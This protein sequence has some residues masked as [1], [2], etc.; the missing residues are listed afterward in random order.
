MSVS[1][2]LFGTT[3]QYRSQQMHDSYPVHLTDFIQ[4]FGLLMV[5]DWPTLTIERVS[6]NSQIY[7]GVCAS[8]M[9]GGS[10]ENFVSLSEIERVHKA[11]S[12]LE[13]QPSVRSAY[14]RLCIELSEEEDNWQ[15]FDCS[16]HFI[17]NGS[18]SDAEEKGIK[19]RSEDETIR[20]QVI[21]EME[22][23]DLHSDLHSSDFHSM[24]M[25]LQLQTQ[26]AHSIAHLRAIRDIHSFTQSAAEAM[27]RLTGYDRVMF[28]QFDEQSAGSVIAEA[29]LPEDVSYLG[30]RYPATDIPALVRQFYQRGMVRFVPDLRADAIALIPHSA[31]HGFETTELEV[32]GNSPLLDNADADTLPTDLTQAVL[33][34]VDPCCVDFHLNMGVAGFLVLAL[35]KDDSLW[36]LIACHHKTPKYLPYSVRVTAE[37]LSQFV[38][39][40]LSSKVNESDADYLL[41]IK[42]I[43]SDVIAAVAHSED[44]KQVLVSPESRLLELVNA[45]GVAVCLDQD[46]TLIGDTPSRSQVDTLIEWVLAEESPDLM[47][48]NCLSARYPAAT[49]YKEVASGALI[50]K[51]SAIR[52]YL[53]LW[54]R[55][56][57]V[58]TVNWAG[59]PEESMQVDEQGQ[60]VLC[61]RN[62]FAQWKETVQA[63]AYPWKKAEVESAYALK[64]AIV[65]SVL[66][67][68]DE[69]AKMNRAL[70]R[71]NQ[72]LDSFA[73]AASH[74]LKEPLRGITNFSNILLRRHRASLDETGVK[75]LETLVRL[76]KRMDTLID[77]LLRFSRLG[78]TEL[79]REWVDL[80]EVVQKA[81]DDLMT[82]REESASIAEIDVVRSLPS[83]YCDPVLIG[84]VFINLLSNALKY[85]DKS[86]PVIKIGQ[87]TETEQIEK[88]WDID[89][90]YHSSVIYIRDNGIGIHK[91]HYDNVFRLFKRLHERDSYGGGNGIGLALTQKIIERHGG[92]IWLESSQGEG[93]IFYFVLNYD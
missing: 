47:Q 13:R 38:A 11:L 84:E 71:R 85:T 78:Q 32:L 33:R 93:T 30:L 66:K 63:T 9:L 23:A 89:L 20:K 75:R 6:Q 73:Y 42:A 76:T 45:K 72:E 54:F 4:P 55:P 82:G 59:N 2:N 24:E 52:R 43:Q 10:L 67:Q 62:S 90:S 1:S 53:I 41:Q 40:E 12:H 56:E 5:L 22:R 61:P 28:Y 7:L 57:V 27:Q 65:G 86:K 46:V 83:A 37:T 16:F 70:S 14:L 51:I 35:V 58:Q 26:V 87:L 68:A 8:D 92:S 25:Q 69:L 48:T 29:K 15:R 39:A 31:C 19:P 18:E 88:G 49:D 80:D 91:R 77:A 74:D 17:Q 34:G 36:G 3:K 21:L 44:L 60:V 50:L 81:I 64:N 79:R